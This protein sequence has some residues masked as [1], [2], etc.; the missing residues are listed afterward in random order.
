M[1]SE[2]AAKTIDIVVGEDLNGDVYEALTIDSDGRVIKATAATDVI[3]GFL[4]EDPGRTTVD[5]TDSVPVA[6]VGGGGRVKVKAQAAIT[7]GYLII[8]TTTAGRVAGAANIGA[9]IEDQMACG[10]ALEAATAAGDIIEILAM[11]IGA[12]HSA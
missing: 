12:P 8:P 10:I 11:P 7:A 5:G 3:V 1:S 6:L 4:A 9:L 2:N